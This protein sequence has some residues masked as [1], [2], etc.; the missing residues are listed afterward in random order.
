MNREITL[1]SV[2]AGTF[3]AAKEGQNRHMHSTKSTKYHYREI[4]DRKRRN[5]L[6]GNQTFSVFNLADSDA[7]HSLYC[8]SPH[9]LFVYGTSISNIAFGPIFKKRPYGHSTKASKNKGF[10]FLTVRRKPAVALSPSFKE[11][12]TEKPDRECLRV[13]RT[14]PSSKPQGNVGMHQVRTVLFLCPEL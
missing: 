6:S 7:I 12:K 10:N 9:L 14:I 11:Q 13:N 5:L 4:E 1:T 8:G 2:L 3:K